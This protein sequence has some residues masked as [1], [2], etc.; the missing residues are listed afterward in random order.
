MDTPLPRWAVDTAA[1][2]CTIL[3]EDTDAPLQRLAS[4]VSG[5]V[6]DSSID[7]Y[8]ET[9]LRTTFTTDEGLTLT[10]T[11]LEY[12]TPEQRAVFVG[13][14]VFAGAETPEPIFRIVL[15]P[16]C[17]AA[18]ARALSLDA[19]GLARSIIRF[20][21]AQMTLEG[22][23][24]LNPIVP[25]GVD[26]GG[27]R[28]VQVGT[29]VAYD[30]SEIAGRLARD[31]SGVI[32][33]YD[34]KDGDLRPYDRDPLQ[35]LLFARQNGTAVASLLLDEAPESSLI[36]FRFAL[37]PDS[38]A[39]IPAE[40]AR[41]GARVVMLPHSAG[42]ETDWSGFLEA[43]RQF[44]HMLFVAT[45]GTQG[46]DIDDQ[47]SYPAGLRAPNFISVTSVEADGHFT[48]SG[49]WGARSVDLAVPAERMSILLASGTEGLGSGAGFAVARVAAMA[50]RILHDD[51]SL[52]GAAV[53]ARILEAA[54]PLPGM[55]EAM[56]TY[57]WIEDPSG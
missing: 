50:A 2:M 4:A 36:P 10:L 1:R 20:T 28:V 9:A 57:G 7:L 49:N 18:S 55:A 27:I 13:S 44:P 41:R 53:K 34:F 33:G 54:E 35:P 6:I 29:G 11:A 12:G 47:P 15:Q 8:S 40:A 31:E 3:S 39:R 51:P 22:V 24:K 42:S 43:A 19:D 16:D 52:T 5:R 56:T 32:L 38:L 45:A 23:D 30:R 17:T 46:R 21:G 37:S 14:A 48:R 25:D 26:P